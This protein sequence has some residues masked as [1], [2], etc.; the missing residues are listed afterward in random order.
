VSRIAVCLVLCTAC[1]GHFDEQA[2]H[3]AAQPDVAPMCSAIQ[4]PQN[5]LISGTLVSATDDLVASCGGAGV[6]EAIYAIDVPA[7]AQLLAA[8]DEPGT[9]ADT[10]LSVRSD[11]TDA[12]SELVCD[13][14]LGMGDNAAYRLTQVPAGRY[15]VFVDG[16][17]AGDYAGRVQTLLPAAATC[18]AMNGRDICAP[19]LSC[20]GGTCMPAACPLA[21]SLSGANTYSRTATT[22]GAPA[23]HAGSCGEG[24][25]GGTRAPEVIY[26]L[27]IPVG[28]VA[29]VR[30]S[31]DSPMTDYDSLIYMRRLTCTGVEVGCDDD[32]IDGAGPSQFDTGPISA[33][34]YY[35]FVDGFGTRSGTATL[36]VTITP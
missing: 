25:D 9:T 6:S 20:S 5:G 35:I 2:Q 27:I 7:G 11:C 32:A 33:G 3:D 15:Y 18:D 29:N 22:T 13:V 1:R 19:E 28:G 8:A 26:Q 24:F 4:V 36:T 14:D 34:D 16:Q 12:T 31:T 30:V 10:M 23:R 17:T 21:D